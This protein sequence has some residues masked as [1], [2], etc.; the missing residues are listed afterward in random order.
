MH[1]RHFE[2]CYFGANYTR[3]NI[4][5]YKGDFCIF[6]ILLSR[7]CCERICKTFKF[8]DLELDKLN[9]DPHLCSYLSV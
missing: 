8:T 7:L 4:S 9:F 6:S 5:N 1:E 3:Q 2:I